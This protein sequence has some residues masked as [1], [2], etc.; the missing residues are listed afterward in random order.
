MVN[1]QVICAAGKTFAA[2][3]AINCPVS[4]PK[5]AGLPVTAALASLQLAP[6]IVKKELAPSEICTVEFSVVTLIAV[7][8][9]GAG[10]PAVV[11]VM[12]AGAEAR[13]ETAKLKAPPG[14][15]V[16]IF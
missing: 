10:V 4:V 11:V 2:G 12:G 5:L 3:M 6:E 8:A 15:P 9:G 1:L 16:V 14:A 7:G 13:L